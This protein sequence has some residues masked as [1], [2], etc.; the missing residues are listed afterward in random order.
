M[1][2]LTDDASQKELKYLADTTSNPPQPCAVLLGGSKVG[3]KIA[4]K[5]KLKDLS[6]KAFLST[7]EEGEE[8]ND[9]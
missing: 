7:I 4:T 1:Q 8:E 6:I 3:D 9:K 5:L 2:W